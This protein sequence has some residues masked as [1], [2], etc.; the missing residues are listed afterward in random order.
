MTVRIVGGSLG[1][2]RSGQMKW[3]T[4]A[5]SALSSIALLGMLVACASATTT[6]S[7][8]KEVVTRHLTAEKNNDTRAWVG[9]LTPGRS[10][11][12]DLKLGV[13]SLDIVGVKEETNPR[14]MEE[15]LASE[16]AGQNSWTK[17]NYAFIAA[18]YDVQYDNTLVPETNGRK[19]MVFKLVRLAGNTPW[20]IKDWGDARFK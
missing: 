9:T 11:S 7:S 17:D 5:L 10:Y 1:G 4:A 3:V 12:D 6:P 19:E 16:E 20:L 2:F 14:Y 13:V 8:P 15:A 18:S